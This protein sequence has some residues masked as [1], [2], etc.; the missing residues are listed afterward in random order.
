MTILS[1]RTR[2]MPVPTGRRA[3]VG[4]LEVSHIQIVINK[5]GTPYRVHEYRPVLN[6]QVGDRFGDELL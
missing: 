6:T 5:N 3:P 4:Y 1:G 2:L